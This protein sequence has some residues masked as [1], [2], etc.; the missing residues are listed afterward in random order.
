VISLANE[1]TTMADLTNPDPHAFPLESLDL[2]G[3]PVPEPSLVWML[4]GGVLGLRIMS[5]RSRAA[6]TA[7]RD[8]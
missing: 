7:P 8:S 5:R 1:L 6:R 4:A 3:L 2:D